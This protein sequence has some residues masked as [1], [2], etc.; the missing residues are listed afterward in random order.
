MSVNRLNPSLLGIILGAFIG[1]LL[2]WIGFLKL[3]IIALLML[4]GYAI[5]KVIES[6]ELRGRI[7]ELLSLLFR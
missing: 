1:V 5:G 2:V 7:K 3:L 6:E 4:V